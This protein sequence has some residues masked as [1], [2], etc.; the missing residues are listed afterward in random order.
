MRHIEVE[1]FDGRHAFIDNYL[2]QILALFKSY[3]MV[4]P[5]LKEA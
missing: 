5:Q 1:Y 4:F 2:L 3:V